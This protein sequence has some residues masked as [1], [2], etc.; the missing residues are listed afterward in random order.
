MSQDE[1]RLKIAEKRNQLSSLRVLPIEVF[2]DILIYA[3]LYYK[4]PRLDLALVCRTWHL[5]VLSIP[6]IWGNISLISAV[7]NSTKPVEWLKKRLELAKNVTLDITLS[8]TCAP[9]LDPNNPDDMRRKNEVSEKV[10]KRLHKVAFASGT[11]RWRSLTIIDGIRSSGVSSIQQAAANIAPGAVQIT[12]FPGGNAEFQS[13]VSA[14]VQGAKFPRLTRL[15]M[16][17]YTYMPRDDAYVELYSAIAKTATRL[18]ECFLHEAQ[19]PLGFLKTPDKL[20]QG[21]LGLKAGSPML[22]V[23]TLP[24]T[25]RYL[26]VPSTDFSLNFSM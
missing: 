25:V 16:Q 21:F 4:V 3:H 10:V 12:H 2:D 5:A 11:E 8:A 15:D 6:R 19:I 14:K 13:W 7:T 20:F 18:E 26:D 24:K 9:F 17:G 1:I 22:D 23:L